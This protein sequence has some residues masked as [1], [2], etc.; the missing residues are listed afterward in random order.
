MMN[1]TK[2]K[3][4]DNMF[5]T[6]IA[7]YMCIFTLIM[8]PNFSF[9]AMHGLKGR[10]FNDNDFT[11]Q[12]SKNI[13]NENPS[14]YKSLTSY[15][16][17]GEP[18]VG[19]DGAYYVDPYINFG[20][21]G[22]LTLGSEGCTTSGLVET[23]GTQ[24]RGLVKCAFGSLI[25]HKGAVPLGRPYQ[26]E[27]GS[28]GHASQNWSVRWEG[29]LYI[30]DT[31]NY[32][33]WTQAKDGY[34]IWI[35]GEKLGDYAATHGFWRQLLLKDNDLSLNSGFHKIRIDFKKLAG[36]G[37]L[38]IG[39]TK[40]KHDAQHVKIFPAKNYYTSLPKQISFSEGSYS[41]V[42]GQSIKVKVKIDKLP[43]PGEEIAIKYETKPRPNT[44]NAEYL[45]IENKDY[46][47]TEG[48]LVFTQAT[49]KELELE[50]PTYNDSE[51]EKT[52]V[53][54]ILL[55]NG[56][57]NADIIETPFA[58]GQIYD[59]TPKTAV[60]FAQE[61]TYT[62]EG[63]NK[64][65]P[66]ILKVPV[67]LTKPANKDISVTL[68]FRNA[69]AKIY[70]DFMPRG[71]IITIKKGKTTGYAEVAIL[72]EGH[73]EPKFEH[74]FID[75]INP[76]GIELGSIT[77]TKIIIRDKT[78][79]NSI[80]LC[81]EQSNDK[82]TTAT[83][84]GWQ[85]ISSDEDWKVTYDT[86]TH[87]FPVYKKYG[88]FPQ[89]KQSGA[90]MKT[91]NKPYYSQNNALKEKR[92]RLAEGLNY[93]TT[94]ITHDSVFP[95]KGN[96]ISLE[97]NLHAYGGC[98]ID[99]Y[100]DT[101]SLCPTL[102]GA[103]S[104]YGGD[105]MALVLYDANTTDVNIGGSG[106]SLG[107]AQ[108]IVSDK[109]QKGFAGG[110]LG[111]GLDMFGNYINP[112]EG[113]E[114]GLKAGSQ[115]P[116]EFGNDG[117]LQT[118]YRS[119]VT[120]RGSGSGTF[121][122]KY[123]AS[124]FPL[125]NQDNPESI[126]KP[127]GRFA[128][129]PIAYDDKNDTWA[130]SYMAGESGISTRIATDYDAGRFRLSIDN[131]DPKHTWIKLERAVTCKKEN[132]V[133]L[134]DG[135]GDDIPDYKIIIENFDAQESSYGQA[136][137]P[138]DLKLAFT[139]AT[140]RY[141]NIMEMGKI[142]LKANSCG[143]AT[144]FNEFRVVELD[145]AK[146][147]QESKIPTKWK[148][149][150]PPEY[151]SDKLWYWKWNS[152]LRTKILGET[153][154]YCVLAGDKTDENASRA[155]QDKKVNMAL[156][157]DVANG[158]DSDG[159]TNTAMSQSE[160]TYNGDEPTNK[161]NFNFRY[162]NFAQGKITKIKDLPTDGNLTVFGENSANKDEMLCFDINTSRSA[163]ISKIGSDASKTAFNSASQN[164][165]FF[166][167][168]INK[169]GSAS[170]HSSDSFALRPEHYKLS[171]QAKGSSEA[172]EPDEQ[173]QTILKSGV[174]Y[175]VD[176]KAMYKTTSP[177]INTT[178]GYF[179]KFESKY[180]NYS[181]NDD[182]SML[183]AILVDRNTSTDLVCAYE[184]NITL[185][186]IEKGQDEST[187][188]IQNQLFKQYMRDGNLE[189]EVGDNV[190]E[191]N[192][193]SKNDFSKQYDNTMKFDIVMKD[194]A[195]TIVDFNKTKNNLPTLDESLN[196][197]IGYGYECVGH[198]LNGFTDADM[199]RLYG[200]SGMNL[201]IP[202]TCD[203][204]QTMPQTVYF[205]PDHF[206]GKLKGLNDAVVRGTDSF[207]YVST[208]ENLTHPMMSADMNLTIQAM[209]F[210]DHV[211]TN[212]KE[213]CYANDV[214]FNITF[215]PHKNPSRTALASSDINL[216]N[217]QRETYLAKPHIWYA[218]DKYDTNATHFVR[219]TPTSTD[220]NATFRIMNK[221]FKNGEAN[222]SVSFNFKRRPNLALEPF[223][224]SDRDF[225]LIG[226]SDANYT[227]RNLNSEAMP[228]NK[229]V[230]YDINAT[231]MGFT[232]T[233]KPSINPMTAPT[234][235]F[236]E[237][238]T[239]ESNATFYTARAYTPDYKGTMG[240]P[241]DGTTYY[242]IYCQEC[243]KAQYDLDTFIS[244]PLQ[245]LWLVN[246]RHN[247]LSP[248][249][250]ISSYESI[251]SGIKNT[252]TIPSTRQSSTAMTLG[253]ER[254]EFRSDTPGIDTIKMNMSP[255]LVYIQDPTSMMTNPNDANITFNVQFY[256]QSEWGGEGRID[257]ASEVQG[258]TV[259]VNES[260]TN[261]PSRKMSW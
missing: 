247:Q 7:K 66:N 242:G 34:D 213:L 187:T 164:A 15:L 78:D 153:N 79:Y 235:N 241:I 202:P 170:F 23:D 25:Q 184:N 238:P 245:P 77:T 172:V 60:E 91:T 86:I 123:L 249:G 234:D 258:A 87:Y 5:F 31:A 11:K 221:D 217:E 144:E 219:K 230:V 185:G 132:G 225:D 131:V 120:I 57:N 90:G 111:V 104:K 151:T 52:E 205:T 12:T 250:N 191:W 190:K 80:N 99:C 117:S 215:A 48:L 36:D 44:Q 72:N 204:N 32:R 188:T 224:I 27:A 50:I 85:L 114:K 59:I 1:Y 176:S 137:I 192:K 53:F 51:A 19:D 171:F 121:G 63:P 83:Q 107:Y 139:S 200:Q 109:V 233:H 178:F 239:A 46:K 201:T 33:I 71:N 214:D 28:Y 67:R 129:Q 4:G 22:W 223:S 76:Q 237:R 148:W 47:K 101:A 105:G 64:N 152:P 257:G 248:D 229:G 161:A 207:T 140:G 150:Q 21:G 166:V 26:I 96:F 212:Y 261:R 89:F 160:I 108:R 244:I 165:Y 103:I 181:P 156:F 8:L 255:W 141:C 256:D 45:A 146:Q 260:I 128:L 246:E 194:K 136:P 206:V 149:T 119:N 56:P 55:S 159:K 95:A 216:T 168:D 69:T 125:N 158:I 179:A 218:G 142:S 231:K 174:D 10:Y 106:G 102:L 88:S 259:D 236:Y 193:P 251:G 157:S 145:Y 182:Y 38:K 134:K 183:K 167:Y 227:N 195:W 154:T 127:L 173:N 41:A 138:K 93:R 186:K 243:D 75:L 29:Y 253:R 81:F 110:W 94:G 197:L 54:D 42:E 147:Q 222:A 126:Q 209:T 37:Y 113:R 112:S 208:E 228:R 198:R 124:Y 73:I 68:K 39:Y 43:E 210:L 162:I 199:T 16:I 92:L 122:Y 100:K 35:D 70:E 24:P 155:K 97:F 49:G 17:P 3:Q 252:M 82:D 65:T 2:Q 18:F 58:V 175:I 20:W 220:E 133:C 115:G 14:Y 189:Y 13:Y 143:P 177:D 6:K 84:D 180:A 30:E 130:V 98:T 169:G 211:A 62:E 135:N 196:R 203:I 118:K 240:T 40:D 116:N 61:Q 226:I 163:P 74:F 232:T 9:A 254:L